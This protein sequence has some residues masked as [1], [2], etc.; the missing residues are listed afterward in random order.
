[1]EPGTGEADGQ[2]A[3]LE[4]DKMGVKAGGI[5][6]CIGIACLV[7]TPIGGALI[8]QRVDR[9]MEQPYLAAQIFAGACLL[10]GGGFLL[11]SRVAK[12]GW[13]ARRA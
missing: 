7:G 10:V 12:V 13:A 9:G 1:M 4:T 5:F 8:S 2:T 3:R 11:V 6:S